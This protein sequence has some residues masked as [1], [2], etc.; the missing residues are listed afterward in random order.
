MSL[1]DRRGPLTAL[2]L[3]AAYALLALD[4]VLVLAQWGQLVQL[5]P[6]S[7]AHHLLLV[8]GFAGL[9]WRAAFKAMFVASEYGW[10]EAIR[11]VLRIPVAN[12][13]AI[14]AGRRALASYLRSLRGGP[15][16]WDK[17]EHQAHPVTTLRGAAA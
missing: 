17:T 7:P 11:A 9:A 5:P 13:I 15:V 3:A 8:I 10:G 12:V 4:A 14:M 1:R 6:L 16:T 2:V